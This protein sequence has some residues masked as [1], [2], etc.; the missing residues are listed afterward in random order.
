M[1]MAGFYAGGILGGLTIGVL[2]DVIKSE[3]HTMAW[4]IG[5]VLLG[6][7]GGAI[8]ASIFRRLLAAGKI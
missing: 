7:V 3:I 8:A 6:A 2:G 5:G 4:Y 1:E